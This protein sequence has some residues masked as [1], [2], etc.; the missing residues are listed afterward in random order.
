MTSEGTAWLVAAVAGLS[1]VADDADG[2][3][4]LEAGPRLRLPC[5]HPLAR[6]WLDSLRED[7]AAGRRVYVRYEP[8]TLAVEDVLQ[9][10]RWRVEAVGGEPHQGRL[11][12]VLPLKPSTYFLSA[13]RPELERWRAL[14]AAAR[15]G[16]EEVE[17]VTDPET[18]EILHVAPVP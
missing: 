17:L 10:F 9:T 16:G 15:E 6:L 1:D 12:V 5:G 11:A 18:G 8:A 4:T 3:V 14:L 13:A 2:T 7:A